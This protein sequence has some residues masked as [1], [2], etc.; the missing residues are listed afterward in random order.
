MEYTIVIVSVG[1]CRSAHWDV[2][3]IYCSS[4]LRSILLPFKSSDGL[5]QCITSQEGNE[6]GEQSS[7]IASQVEYT[8]THIVDHATPNKCPMVRYSAG[9]DKV[10]RVIATLRSTDNGA[11]RNERP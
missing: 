2:T 8:I 7:T 4:T 5:V 3:T 9:V 6:L 11:P 1:I 10:Q